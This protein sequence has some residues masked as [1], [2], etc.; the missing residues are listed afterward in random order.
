[1]MTEVRSVPKK[2]A[3]RGT[4]HVARRPVIETNPKMMTT[5]TI[6]TNLKKM[7]TRMIPTDDVPPLDHAVWAVIRVLDPIPRLVRQGVINIFEY[8]QQPICHL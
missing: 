6:E 5:M 3:H 7:M 1:M 2:P 8:E 4:P